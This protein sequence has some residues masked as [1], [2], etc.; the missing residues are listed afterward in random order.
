MNQGLFAF[1]AMKRYRSVFLSDFHMGSKRFDAPALLDFLQSFECEYL[2]L[3]GDIIDGWKL[4]KRWYWNEDCNRILDELLRKGA[5]GTKIIYLPGNHDNEM[6]QMQHY[7]F[8]QMARKFNF[9]IRDRVIHTMADGRQFL[10]MHGDQFDSKILG[11]NISRWFDHLYNLINRQPPRK[12]TINQKKFSLAKTL[13][14]HSKIALMLLNNFEHAVYKLAQARDV[15]GLI[16]GHT[17]VPAQKNLKGISY[18]NSGSWVGHQHTAIVENQAGE[19][20]LIDCPSSDD[21]PTLFDHFTFDTHA[22]GTNMLKILPTANSYRPA[23]EKIVA[24]IQALWP[25]EDTDATALKPVFSQFSNICNKKLI[26][27]LYTFTT[28]HLKKFRNRVNPIS[29]HAK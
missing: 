21:S 15:D 10:I 2:F 14:K 8:R 19:L 16:C 7:P 3:S 4:A 25:E 5:N 29:I 12:L 22:L 20:G 9:K 11:E 17:H 1:Q 23:T 18:Y 27:T 6:R 24:A 26:T 13:K 28:K